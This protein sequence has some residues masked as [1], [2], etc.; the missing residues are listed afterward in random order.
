MAVLPCD[1][2]II[3]IASSTAQATR[4]IEAAGMLRNIRLLLILRDPLHN[5]RSVER[6]ADACA[7]TTTGPSLLVASN[8]V[9]DRSMDAIHLPFNMLEKASDSTLAN[10]FGVSVHSV[11]EAVAAVK[12]SPAY[13]LASPVFPTPSKPGHTGIGCDGIGA[14]ASIDSTPVFALGGVT[15]DHVGNLLR[16]GARGVASIRAFS[17]SVDSISAALVRF[18][19][20]LRFA[21]GDEFVM[22]CREE[23]LNTEG[24]V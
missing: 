16:S 8:G 15:P 3:A 20:E 6:M 10:P 7:V 1:L 11:E 2:R 14:I 4:I 12:H 17:G 22:T 21:K 24:T 13:L 19:Q 5:P 23:A 9:V 18:D